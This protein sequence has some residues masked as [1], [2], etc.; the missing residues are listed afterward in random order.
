MTELV[1]PLPAPDKL[2]LSE[3]LFLHESGPGNCHRAGYSFARRWQVEKQVSI[4]EDR[5]MVVA[6]C[7]TYGCE[8]VVGWVH[9]SESEIHQALTHI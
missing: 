5:W 3:A 7:A 6:H 1:L 4:D 8:S 9:E 2:D